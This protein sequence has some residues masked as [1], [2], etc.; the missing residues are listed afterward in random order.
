MDLAIFVTEL[1]KRGNLDSNLDSVRL[2]QNNGICE[3]QQLQ[4]FKKAIEQKI[5]S[6]SIH[7]AIPILR[8][9]ALK[10]AT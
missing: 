9:I 2:H 1:R 4:I 7:E 6:D 5:H 3:L 10:L 8:F